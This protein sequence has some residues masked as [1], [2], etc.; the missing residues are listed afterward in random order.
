MSKIKSY[1]SPSGAK[2][3]HYDEN[4][5]V[6]G[7]SYRSLSGGKVTHYDASGNKT[8]V[9][10]RSPSGHMTHYNSD[11]SKTGYS[12]ET[13]SG[14]VKHYD[15]NYNKTGESN[16]NFWGAHVTENRNSPPPQYSNAG[17][18]GSDSHIG[19]WLFMAVWIFILIFACSRI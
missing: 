13:Y 2:T 6:V 17:N 5:N 14:Q 12:Q 19:C 15:T 11:G 3:T 4:G 1:T 18:S 7:T 16:R 8:G 9:S 10:Y